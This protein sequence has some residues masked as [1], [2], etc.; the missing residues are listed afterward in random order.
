MELNVEKF[1][2]FIGNGCVRSI[3]VSGYNIKVFGKFDNLIVV[4]YLNLIVI[5]GMLY[6]VE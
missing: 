3:F 4:G 5:F 6:V 2:F 1:L